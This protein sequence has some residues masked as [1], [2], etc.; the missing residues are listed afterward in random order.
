MDGE[1]CE[2]Y[3]RAPARGRCDEGAGAGCVIVRIEE[4]RDCEPRK[5]TTEPGMFEKKPNS[6]KRE[7]RG[8][9]QLNLNPEQGLGFANL[10]HR[11][12]LLLNHYFQHLQVSA[13]GK[14]FD[15]CVS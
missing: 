3:E 10:L 11:F 1:K 4:K 6:L 2:V 8:V 12:D 15:R 5:K 13:C 14:P 7:C 9:K